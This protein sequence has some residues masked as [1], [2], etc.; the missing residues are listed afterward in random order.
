MAWVCQPSCFL[1]LP[2]NKTKENTKK[3]QENELKE[4]QINVLE[5]AQGLYPIQE[6]KLQGIQGK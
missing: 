2:R 4:L 5:D 6:A 3:R 1:V